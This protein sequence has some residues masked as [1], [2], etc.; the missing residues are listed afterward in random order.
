M[1][2]E[3]TS[4]LFRSHVETPPCPPARWVSEWFVNMLGLLFPETAETRFR[5]RKAFDQY[6]DGLKSGLVRILGEQC[7]PSDSSM[8]QKAEQFFFYLPELKRMLDMDAQAMF[9]GDPAASSRTEVVRS[10]PGFYAI[11]AH[12]MAHKLLH[13]GVDL[14]PRA[15]SEHAHRTT[16]ID[17]NPGAIIGEHFCID[18]GTGV[19]IGQTT[20]IGD[21]VKIY[22]GVTLGALSVS[23]EDATDKRHPTIEDDVVIYAGATILGGQTVVGKGSVIGGNVWLTRSVVPGTKVYYAA[24]MTNEAGE[25][26]TVI[27]KG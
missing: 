7:G 9:D 11:A 26:D 10:Y 2:Q 12:R 18:H 15:L 1:D 17:I 19:V 22:Q 13:L 3:F 14:V 8:L 6:V 25:V 5:D 27:M 24:K 16:G 23:K 20:V 21:R 4:E